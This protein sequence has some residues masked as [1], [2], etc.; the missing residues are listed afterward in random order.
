MSLRESEGRA[1]RSWVWREGRNDVI[2]YLCMSFLEI[3]K[4]NLKKER[5]I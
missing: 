1:G 2:Q 3:N 4:I 5:G